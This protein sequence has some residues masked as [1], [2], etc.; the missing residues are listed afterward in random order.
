MHS[1]PIHVNSLPTN[2]NS[3]NPRI[4]QLN[5]EEL[6]VYFFFSLMI[7]IV[8]HEVLI[9]FTLMNSRG[10]DSWRPNRRTCIAAFLADVISDKCCWRTTAKANNIGEAFFDWW[11][12]QFDVSV[13]WQIYHCPCYPF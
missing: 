11:K 3:S 12:E 1:S 10:Y 8:F 2:N 9:Q 13:G 6:V 4:I 5:R 7:V